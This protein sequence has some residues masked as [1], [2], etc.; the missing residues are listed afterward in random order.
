MGLV[1]GGRLML[2]SIMRINRG[3]NE[4]LNQVQDDVLEVA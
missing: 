2:T 1:Y 3:H 4:I